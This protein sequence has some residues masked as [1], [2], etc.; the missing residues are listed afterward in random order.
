MLSS[1][2]AWQ[3]WHIFA[4]WMGM[5]TV[6]FWSQIH[7]IQQKFQQNPMAFPVKDGSPMVPEEKTD[8]LSRASAAFAETPAVSSE[9]WKSTKLRSSLDLSMKQINDVS[10]KH[11]NY[12]IIT[13]HMYILYN[14]YICI[15]HMSLHD[16]PFKSPFTD[17]DI[18]LVQEICRLDMSRHLQALSSWH[19]QV[20][21]LANVSDL[22]GDIQ[23]VDRDSM[24]LAKSKRY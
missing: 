21:R 24:G 23:N 8:F 2:H 17:Y 20:L 12:I 4:F 1:L 3:G 9:L 11:S 22:L 5:T 16:S 19:V 15:Y 7:V 6:R 18:L 13:V 14:I 10:F